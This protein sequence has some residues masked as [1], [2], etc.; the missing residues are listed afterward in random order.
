MISTRLDGIFFKTET[1]LLLT[2]NSVSGKTRPP[3]YFFSIF[4]WWNNFP[5]FKALIRTPC[6]LNF[7]HS[8]LD[9]VGP[10]NQTFENFYEPASVFEINDSQQKAENW[11]SCNLCQSGQ[12]WFTCG[13]FFSTNK[14]GKF[15][16]TQ[17]N[18]IWIVYR[19][20]CS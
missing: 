17:R 19:R 11:C 15:E 2:R 1:S 18:K 6:L 5:F 13:E 7:L 3:Q 16:L 10:T 20:F 9:S 12:T 4:S 8:D 14:P